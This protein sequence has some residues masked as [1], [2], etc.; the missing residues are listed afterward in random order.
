[1]SKKS[2]HQD[3][4]VAPLKRTPPGTKSYIQ[5]DW[6][7]REW[8]EGVNTNLKK[9]V[10]FLNKFE[11]STKFRLAKINEKLNTLERQV[12]FLEAQLGSLQPDANE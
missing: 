11:T 6:E 9:V 4:D 2:K 1:M 5:A 12:T 3:L 10:E 8:I 7:Q